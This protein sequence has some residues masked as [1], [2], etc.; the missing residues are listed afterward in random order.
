MLLVWLC[1][2]LFSQSPMKEGSCTVLAWQYRSQNVVDA[3]RTHLAHTPVH[4]Q[5]HVECCMR[6]A[7]TPII[8]GSAHAHASCMQGLG[9]E[10][11]PSG[12]CDALCASYPSPVLS[13][14]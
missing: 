4:V 7:G 3:L 8:A 11:G 10:D 1:S 9:G 12:R 5:G 14:F 6:G 13:N 2:V